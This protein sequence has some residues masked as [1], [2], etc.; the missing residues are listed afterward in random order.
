MFSECGYP[1]SH[2]SYLDD[3]RDWLVRGDGN[4]R[5]VVLVGWRPSQTTITIREHLELYRLDK[6]DMPSLR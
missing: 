3:V 5:A 4:T 6:N 1:Q 2:E